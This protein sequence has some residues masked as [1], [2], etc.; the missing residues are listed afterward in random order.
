[1]TK[2]FNLTLAAG[3]LT[4]AAVLTPVTFAQAAYPGSDQAETAAVQ[5]AID[6]DLGLRVDQVRA[7]TV[8]GV[9]YL[10]GRVDSESAVA[11]ADKIAQSVVGNGKV[12]NTLTDD[13]F[14]G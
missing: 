12:V 9:V 8:D 7:Q 11:R 3:L 1:M 5:S 14:Q 10:H 6:Q 4:A 13:Q 2:T